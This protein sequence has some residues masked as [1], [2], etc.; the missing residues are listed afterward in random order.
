VEARSSCPELRI[1]EAPL[2][3]APVAAV[4]I[5]FHASR[6]PRERVRC[7]SFRSTDAAV[8]LRLALSRK[9]IC[10]LLVIEA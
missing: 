2:E 1:P 9:C 5:Q 8:L 10:V 4:T 3:R 6:V 7:A